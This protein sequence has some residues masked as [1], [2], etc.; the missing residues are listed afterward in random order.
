MSNAGN[1]IGQ[2]ITGAR[3]FIS[4]LSNGLTVPAFATGGIATGPTFGLFGEAGDEA[5]LPL[6]NINPIID[7]A[8]DRLLQGRFGGSIVT[9]LDLL[10]L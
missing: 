6:S 1:F 5:I 8:V 4:G 2:G 9:I 3:N 10:R 7:A